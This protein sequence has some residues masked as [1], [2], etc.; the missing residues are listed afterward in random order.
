M[1]IRRHKKRFEAEV[2]ASS[3]SDIMFFLMLFFLIVS[4]LVNP[5]VIKLMLPKASSAQSFSKKSFSLEMSLDKQYSLDGQRI[6]FEEIEPRLT[7]ATAGIDEP[8]VVLRIDN[9]LSVQDLVDVLAIGNKLK[10]K[11]IM[12]TQAPK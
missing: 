10:V 6:T 5:S 1:N 2:G 11:M 3:M 8:T 12:A 9:G 7:A 4:T